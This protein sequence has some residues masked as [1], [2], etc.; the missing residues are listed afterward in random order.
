MITSGTDSQPG[1]GRPC[2]YYTDTDEDEDAAAAGSQEEEVCMTITEMLRVTP[3][4]QLLGAW[5]HDG[6]AALGSGGFGAVYRGHLP[7]PDGRVIEAVAK[8]YSAAGGQ[9]WAH[10]RRESRAMALL[11]ESGAASRGCTLRLYAAGAHPVD[12]RPMLLVELAS[13][14]LFHS[15]RAAEMRRSYAG[16]TSADAMLLPE[17]EIVEVLLAVACALA[18]MHSVGVVHQDIKPE[19]VLYRSN[20]DLCVAD[21]GLAVVLRHG[22]RTYRGGA[23][24]TSWF[25]APELGLH[26]PAL[27]DWIRLRRSLEEQEQAVAAG[28]QRRPR[29]MAGPHQAVEAAAAAAAAVAATPCRLGAA[30]TAPHPP[31]QAGNQ[32]MMETED[33]EATETEETETETE[34]EDG[35]DGMDM[36][37]SLEG[38]GASD[39]ASDSDSES[40]SSDSQQSQQSVG[41]AGAPVLTPAVDVWSLGMLALC[42][43]VTGN[44]V[45]AGAYRVLRR[46]ELPGYVPAWLAALIRD[47]TEWAPDA[48][49]SAAQVLAR[50]QAVKRD[51]GWA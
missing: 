20:G 3:A 43:A 27:S 5:Q 32:E 25:A 29:V 19:N 4:E 12:G 40:S 51:A 48:R 31:Q 50:L 37:S 41:Q 44:A 8:M 24:G 15:L 46:H 33:E 2:F 9:G 10:M 28:R 13:S 35:S 16:R 49:P 14:C 18:E 1:D 47:C 23:G 6:E 36:G 21:M 45:Q 7:L 34:E 22:R 11:Q 17:A 26:L 39:F 42:V 30:P 38:S